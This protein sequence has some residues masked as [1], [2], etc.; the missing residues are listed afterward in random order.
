MCIFVVLLQIQNNIIKEYTMKLLIY[1]WLILFSISSLQAK[2]KEKEVTGTYVSMVS[3]EGITYF[4]FKI[5]GKKRNFEGVGFNKELFEKHRNEPILIRYDSQF[6]IIDNVYFLDGSNANNEKSTNAKYIGYKGKISV[7]HYL[8]FDLNGTES[9]FRAYDVNP[10]KMKKNIG[11]MYHLVYTE[12][13]D[14]SKQINSL[15][16]GSRPIVVKKPQQ[17]IHKTKKKTASSNKNIVNRL[18]N[19]TYKGVINYPVT[20]KNGKYKSSK[21][22]TSV[23]FVKLLA[24]GDITGDGGTEYIVLLESSGGGSGSFSSLA[25]MKE[26]KH[27][28][29]TTRTIDLGDRNTVLSLKMKDKQLIVKLKDHGPNDPACCPSRIRTHIWKYTSKGMKKIKGPKI[30]L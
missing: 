29:K 12:G 11:K 8:T 23:Y 5:K 22:Y 19:A 10:K 30:L 25:I 7:T 24:K 14:D 15:S 18:K 16:L 20:L 1:F 13:L 9:I 26:K 21:D 4:E 2:E 3:G 6:D 28:L 27:I 17:N